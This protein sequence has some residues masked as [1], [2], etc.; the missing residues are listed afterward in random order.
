LLSLLEITLKPAAAAAEPAIAAASFN[1]G[2]LELLFGK[3]EMHSGA[4]ICSSCKLRAQ[5]MIATN[6]VAAPAQ[7]RAAHPPCSSMHS[8]VGLVACTVMQ[9]SLHF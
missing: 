9:P 1:A 2:Q 3:Q 6:S 4:N 8:C 5:Q 7:A